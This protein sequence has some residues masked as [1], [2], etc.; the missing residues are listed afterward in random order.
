MMH[1]NARQLCAQVLAHCAHAAASRE[2]LRGALS[3]LYS[4][5]SSIMLLWEPA[6]GAA[7]LG[8]RGDSADVSVSGSVGELSVVVVALDEWKHQMHR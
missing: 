6:F 2:Q 4:A 5:N 3:A 1:L 7:V 8:L